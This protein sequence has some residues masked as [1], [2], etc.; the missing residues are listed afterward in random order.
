MLE[1]ALRN[2]AE[3][4]ARRLRREEL[5]AGGVQIKVKLATRLGGGRFQLLTRSRRLAVPTDDGAALGRVARELLRT[6]SLDVPV[7]LVG[8][9]AERLSPVTA[10]QLTLLPPEPEE[11]RSRA[12]NRA[13]DEI[14]RRFG[15]GALVRGTQEPSRAGLSLGVKRGDDP[16]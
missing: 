6:I 5:V 9:A 8:V 3:A 4:V 14:H 11:R 10:E 13:L 16:G 2:H 7:R 1:G 12:L 15:H